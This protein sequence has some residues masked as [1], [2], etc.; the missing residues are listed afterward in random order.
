MQGERRVK[1]LDAVKKYLSSVANETN[2]AKIMSFS[3]SDQF[4]SF[5]I[6]DM[7]QIESID[8]EKEV[9]QFACGSNYTKFLTEAMEVVKTEAQGYEIKVLLISDGEGRPPEE[10]FE[11]FNNLR[12]EINK[13]A[14][15]T[16]GIDLRKERK[17]EKLTRFANGCGGR[18]LEVNEENIYGGIVEVMVYE[19][20][21]KNESQ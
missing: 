13:L 14:L 7:R 2:K 17:K 18:F 16:I 8:F 11:T 4:H 12:T 10:E 19:P 3:C 9:K 20:G 5:P 15:N 21:S 6:E 1:L